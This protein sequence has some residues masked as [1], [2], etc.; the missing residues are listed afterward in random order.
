VV[1]RVG[2]EDKAN[3]SAL[4]E[5]LRQA[6]P[7][8][9]GIEPVGSKDARVSAASVYLQAGNFWLPDANEQTQDAINEA[10]S[11]PRGARDDFID[12]VAHALLLTIGN[13]DSTFLDRLT[14]WST[15]AH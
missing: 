14:K 6:V 5:V 4:I 9:L 13:S 8:V 10:A 15:G 1:G 3:G 12:T 7:G 2:I 11:F